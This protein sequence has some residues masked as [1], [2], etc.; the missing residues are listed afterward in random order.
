MLALS[1]E[2]VSSLNGSDASCSGVCEDHWFPSGHG[3]RRAASS[4]RSERL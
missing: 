4:V 1:L 2:P 3:F